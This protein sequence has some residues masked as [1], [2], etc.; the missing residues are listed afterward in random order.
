MATNYVVHLR[1]LLH[2]IGHRYTAPPPPNLDFLDAF[3]EWFVTRLGPCT[4]W[5]RDRLDVLE[6]VSGTLIERS[7]PYA[8]TEVKMI[9]GT[10]TAVG[11]FMDDS[12][13]DEE[14]CD[15]IASFAHRLYLGE[16]Q[17]PGPILLYH[18]AMKGLS[19]LHEGDAVLRGSAVTPWIL[20]A[21]ACLLEKRLLTEDAGL[22]ASPF[23][24]GY[25]RLLKSR[26]GTDLP[27]HED[28]DINGTTKC[29][30]NPKPQLTPLKGE[31]L[32][33]CVV[34]ALSNFSVICFSLKFSSF[35]FTLISPYYLRQKTA[36]G[37]PYAAAIFKANR[38]QE[39][40]L[41]RYIKAMPD[42]S[43]FVVSL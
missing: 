9:I 3:H 12:I 38:G 6:N 17:P 16:P 36:L 15:Q 5:S 4:T 14:I 30:G 29:N 19:S 25:E 35:Y 20:F 41:T 23:D 40:P 7:Y 28:K 11:I 32:K 24:M 43:F 22:R 27:V 34:C 39:L 31:A 13:D 33:L 2:Q 42:I 37:E 21:D 1:Q 8:D 10:L 26:R 18:E